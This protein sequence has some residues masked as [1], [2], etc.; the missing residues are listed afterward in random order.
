MLTPKQKEI[1]EKVDQMLKDKD[2]EV[3]YEG[4]CIEAKICPKCGADIYYKI[5]KDGMPPY[6]VEYSCSSYLCENIN[7]ETKSCII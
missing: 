3:R 2:D 1:L 4:I 7:V 6:V 5:N